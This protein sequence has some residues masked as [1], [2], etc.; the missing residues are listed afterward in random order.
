MASGK[1]Q[2]RLLAIPVVDYMEEARSCARCSDV[3]VQSLLI[4]CARFLAA[5]DPQDH[6]GTSMATARARGL[7]LFDATWEAED[8]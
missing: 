4:G 2:R 1:L 3:G 7:S 8:T 5:H 6:A